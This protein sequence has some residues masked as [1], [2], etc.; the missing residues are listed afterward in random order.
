MVLI[1]V[2]IGGAFDAGGITVAVLGTPIDRIYPRSN[3]GLARRILEKGAIISEYPVGTETKPYHFLDRNR[4]VSG[5][6]DAIVIVEASRRSGTIH[7]AARAINQ[8]KKLYIVP[9]DI[10]RPMSMGCNEML[11]DSANCYTDF[12]SFVKSALKINPKIQRRHYLAGDEKAIVEQI[13]QGTLFGEEIARNLNLDIV[14]F[15]QLI[16][17]LEIKGVVNSLGCNN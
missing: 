4:I 16:T 7:T 3:Q 2:R 10:T 15:N 17:V 12:D 14:R 9:G 6:A 8:G 13:K 11:N 5:L 1:R